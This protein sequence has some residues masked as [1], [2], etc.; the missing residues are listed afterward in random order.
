M[1]IPDWV[2][3]GSLLEGPDNHGSWEEIVSTAGGSRS[4]SVEEV[5]SAIRAW[6]A[7]PAILT[8]ITGRANEIKTEVFGHGVKV[9]I[10]LYLSN[11]CLNDCLY[12]AYRSG[13][14]SMPRRTLTQDEFRRELAR[15]LGMGYRVIELVTSESHQLKTP[16]TLARYVSVAREMLDSAPRADEP[17]EI[18]L[19]SWALSEDEFR[20]VR[21]AGLDAFYLWQETYDPSAYAMLHPEGTPKADFAWRVGVFERAIRLG[22][23]RVGMGVLFGLSDWARDV[24]SLVA[25]G[26]RI[27]RE[28]GLSVDAVGIPRFKPASGSLVKEAPVQ[29]SDDELRLA[30]ALYRLA[31]PRS[32]VFLN[33]REKLPLLLDLLGCGGSEM[34]MAC[35][36]YPGGYTERTVDKQFEHYSYPAE[37]TLPLLSGKGY[38]PT[39][40]RI[41]AD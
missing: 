39:H 12:C 22:I 41:S 31:F 28:F 10:P 4:L 17:G 18:I 20:S 35:A 6:R 36:V 29:V 13:N 40:F 5:A 3:A 9:F 2:E 32:H 21:D 8:R 33:T 24:L 25:H 16:G 19:M 1:F 34:N 7:D 15:V 37:K 30:V 27:Q 38:K 11:S 26:Q 23:K 14:L